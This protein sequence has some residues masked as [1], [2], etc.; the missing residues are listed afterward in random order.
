V[1]FIYSAALFFPGLR[2]LKENL[3]ALERFCEERRAN[4]IKPSTLRGYRL[5][6]RQ[7]DAFLSKP[8]REATK[9]DMVR[10]CVGLQ[11]R[12]KPITV[13][14]WKAKLKFFYNWLF[15]LEP[16]EYPPCVRWIRSNNPGRRSK[17]KGYEMRVS[18]EDVLTQEDVLALIEACD[19]TR[20]Q[21]LVAVMYDTA[22]EPMEALNMKV[23]SV[24]FDQQGA[25]VSLEGE[26]GVR[27]I[28][29]VKSVPYV[30][31]WLN[32]HPLRKNPEAPL[33]L[34][35]KGGH[36]GLSYS[37]LWK[38]F[39]EL[40]RKSD[41]KK[42]L[43][44]NLLRHA[45]LTEMAKVL[46]EQLLKKFAGWTPDSRMASVY[47]HLAGKD[48]DE[49][50]LRLEGKPVVKEEA[51]LKGALAPKECPRCG[52]ENPATWLW[53]GMCG[54]RLE[55]GPDETKELERDLWVNT[56]FEVTMELREK[57]PEL[58][59]QVSKFEDNLFSMVE[60]RIQAKKK[61]EGAGS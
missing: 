33:W 49:D 8:F 2:M 23:K 18:P 26:T 30:Q 32:I 29:I 56:L 4:E 21:A 14:K 10:F 53:C 58:W 5:T 3:E 22:C 13:H 31:A 61:A 45:R 57:K 16:R 28:R 20:D 17:T 48:L 60:E 15:D 34:L 52:H 39:S 12:L 54:Q 25:V 35:R 36:E 38:L 51:P 7:L 19:H 50:I 9:E 47:I 24:A 59:P 46:P 1:K 37:G 44:P 11:D 41:L 27:R 43:S 55:L 42:P 6:L 40:K